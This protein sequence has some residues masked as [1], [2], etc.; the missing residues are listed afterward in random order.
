MYE[1]DIGGPLYVFGPMCAS[2][3][4][5]E[6]RSR[7]SGTASGAAGDGERLAAVALQRGAAPAELRHAQRVGVGREEPRL[8]EPVKRAGTGGKAAATLAGQL[9]DRGR[10]AVGLS[11]DGDAHGHRQ[12]ELA[13]VGDAG[14]GGGRASGCRRGE[15]DR[16]VDS[17]RRCGVRP[18]GGDRGERAVHVGGLVAE[19]PDR[20]AAPVRGQ[21]S[22][23]ALADAGGVG[24]V[25]GVLHRAVRRNIRIHALCATQHFAGR[26]VDV[27]SDTARCCVTRRGARDHLFPGRTLDP[28]EGEFTV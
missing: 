4:F 23:G 11:R 18:L 21:C 2:S 7:G 26:G 27:R 6:A 1:P 5:G 12:V 10:V 13:V 17:D 3:V 24:D 16:S 9:G 8:G 20:N 19:C 22:V 25:H 28:R 14:D 15:R